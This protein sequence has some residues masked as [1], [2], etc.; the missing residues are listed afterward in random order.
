MAIQQ[1]QSAEQTEL[2]R[3]LFTVDEYK[4][5]IAAEIFRTDEHIELIRGE[6]VQMPPI[7]D[8]H[9]GSVGRLTMLL[10]EKVR[11]AAIV[12]V[13]NPI[14]L[15]NNARPQPDLALVK[16]Q[17]Y[18]TGKPATASDVLLIIEVAETSAKS[19]RSVK[20]PLYAEAGIPEYWLVD[21]R[22]GVIEVYTDP[23]GGAYGSMKQ[24]KRGDTLALPGELGVVAVGDVLSK[25]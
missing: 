9:A 7:G 3:R 17:D 19:D 18:D 20:G 12:W 22:Q 16:R 8:G 2:K 5:M 11:G 15:A 10:A 23:A 24:A 4:R 25:Q 6:I 1:I 21:L 14:Q 13:Q